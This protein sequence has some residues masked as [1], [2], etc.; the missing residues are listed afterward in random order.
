[1]QSLTPTVDA[2]FAPDIDA[3]LDEEGA[4][5]EFWGA[6]RSLGAWY[7]ELPPY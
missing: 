1:M 4:K 5:R 7:D 6:F 3:A 2:L